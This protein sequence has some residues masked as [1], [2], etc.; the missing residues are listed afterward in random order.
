[1]KNPV[2]I[3]LLT[4]AAAL[5]VLSILLPRTPDEP[6]EYVR[7]GYVASVADGQAR[8]LTCDGFTLPAAPAP[9][10]TAGASLDLVL[11]DLDIVSFTPATDDYARYALLSADREPC[12]LHVHGLSEETGEYYS[13][14]VIYTESGEYYP[15]EPIPGLTDG[16]AVRVKYDERGRFFSC[17]PIA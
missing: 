2:R 3:A 14:P 7:C 9:G 12:P 1:M 10:L 13:D 8:I 5:L 6:P 11:R 16:Q 15:R 17:V 4:A